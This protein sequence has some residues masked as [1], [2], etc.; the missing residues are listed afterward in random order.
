MSESDDNIMVYCTCP[1]HDSA[2]ELANGIIEAQLAACINII[3]G[4]TSIYQWK[5]QRQQG[6]EELLLIKTTTDCYKSLEQHITSK[7][8]Y[9]LPELIAVTIKTGLP[10]YLDWVHNS[11][12]LT[13]RSDR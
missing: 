6:T 12:A 3:P 7:H 13:H 4:L 1:D 2:L 8:P 10:A 5:G 9:E 11:C